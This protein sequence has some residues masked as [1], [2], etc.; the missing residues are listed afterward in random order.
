MGSSAVIDS[1]LAVRFEGVLCGEGD[2]RRTLQLTGMVGLDCR[3]R[4]R[5]DPEEEARVIVG[6]FLDLNS[7]IC[8]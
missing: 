2:E 7:C 8:H 1:M 3:S 4:C 6:L 5:R